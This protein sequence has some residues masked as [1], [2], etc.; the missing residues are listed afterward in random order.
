MEKSAK[1]KIIGR[2][3][4]SGE[5]VSFYTIGKVQLDSL[6]VKVEYEEK[7]ETSVDSTTILIS[8]DVVSVTKIGELSH[9]MIFE[10]GKTNQAT[11]STEYGNMNANILTKSVQN[12]MTDGQ[13]DLKMIYA[14]EIGGTVLSNNEFTITVK[15][16]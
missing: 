4:D 5:E 14:I 7:K 16:N 2:N 3:T 1:I 11:L 9:T 13:I 15:Y 8:D 12:Q 10:E 6:S